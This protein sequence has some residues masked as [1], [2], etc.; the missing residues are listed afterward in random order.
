M[1]PGFDGTGPGGMGP[2]TG[3][4]RGFCGPYG[5]SRR[6]YGVR[7]RAGYNDTYRAA[8]TRQ[9]EL[10]FLKDESRVL[11]AHLK[12]LESEIERFLAKEQ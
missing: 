6:P 9:Q 4:G 3:G 11:R 5:A 10:D 12:E 2:M 1:M 7:R 8:P